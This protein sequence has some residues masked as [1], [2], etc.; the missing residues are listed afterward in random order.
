M[1]AKHTH[2]ASWSLVTGATGGIGRAFARHL[3]AQ[4]SDVVITGRREAELGTLTEELE[5]NGV[6]V[7]PLVCDLSVADQRQLLLQELQGLRIG[8]STL[9]NNAGFGML[10]PVAEA[11]P[12]RTA[13]ML[14]VNVVALTEL[15]QMLL[16]PMIE[17]GRGAIIN[18]ASTASFQPVPQMAAYAASKAYVRSFT[19]ALWHELRGTGVRALS[20][21]PGPTESGFFEVA[22]DD[23]VMSAS[24]RT[25]EDVVRTAF[26]ALRANRPSVV[27]GLVNAA[28]AQTASR[29]PARL[30]LGLAGRVATH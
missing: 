29:L 12:E 18:V 1:D 7:L 3:A 10:G 8:V 20:I 22:G 4:G 27:D 13:Q 16:G 17:R 25:P 15:T 21:S 14:Q 23:S 2:P 9:V 5:T 24:R 26:A 30:V 19:E 11:D 6:R 28:A